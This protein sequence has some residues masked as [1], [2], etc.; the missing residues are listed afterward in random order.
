MHFAGLLSRKVAPVT[1]GRPGRLLSA[2]ARRPAR[3]V[4]DSAASAWQLCV[5]GPRNEVSSLILIM[6]AGL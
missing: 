2:F 5:P 4:G 1:P 3:S 6:L